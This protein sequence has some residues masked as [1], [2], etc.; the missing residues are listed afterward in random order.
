MIEINQTNVDVSVLN[1]FNKKVLK[2]DLNN[3]LLNEYANLDECCKL[4]N[5]LKR[6]GI[7]RCLKDDRQT[8]SNF[9]W[10]YKN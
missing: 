9:V 10:K 7:T 3:T 6:S 8:Y 5:E 1:K 2:Y 4:N